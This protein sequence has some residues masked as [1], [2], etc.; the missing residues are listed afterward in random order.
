MSEEEEILEKLKEIFKTTGTPIEV[1]GMTGE[2]ILEALKEI[3][4]SYESNRFI[5]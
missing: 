4:D 1:K 5:K 2:E 3:G